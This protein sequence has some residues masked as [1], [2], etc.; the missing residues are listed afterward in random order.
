MSLS[1]LLPCLLPCC[2]AWH[3]G[4]AQMMMPLMTI[5]QAVSEQQRWRRATELQC[6]PVKGTSHRQDG[7]LEDAREG[8]GRHSV[9]DFM[10]DS[11]SQTDQWESTRVHDARRLL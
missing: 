6:H 9:Y 11:K 5:W 3:K 8:Q 2:K 7:E 1:R 4:M 10:G